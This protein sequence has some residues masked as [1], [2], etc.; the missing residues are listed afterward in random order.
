MVY[1][2]G[3]TLA[4]WLII[5]GLCKVG[6]LLKS[7]TSPVCKCL[8]TILLSKLFSIVLAIAILYYSV[9]FSNDILIPFSSIALAPGCLLHPLII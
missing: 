6:Y 2:L 3:R 4:M 8:N 9:L 7:K 5:L 1:S